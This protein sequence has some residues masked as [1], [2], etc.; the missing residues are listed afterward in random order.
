MKRSKH[1]LSSTHLTSFDMG[2]LVPVNL[3]ETL[4]GDS[5]QCS[6][7]ALI[8]CAPM[9]A[10]PMHPVRVR[11][12]HWFV[13]HRLVWA[14]FENFI[15]GGPDGN[16]A[17]VFPT[18]SSFAVAAGTL[19]N[20]LGLPV[21]TVP[22][23]SALPFRAY[24]L[25]WNEYYRD[26]DLQ[27][28]LTVNTGDGVDATTP[29]T[30][31]NCDWEKDYF[32]SS[33]PWEQKGPAVS[34]PIGTSAP[35]IR[36]PSSGA[37]N[38]SLIRVSSTGATTT[39]QD[40]LQ[41]ATDGKLRSPTHTTGLTLDPN[42]SLIADLSSVSGITVNALRQSLALQR[43]EEAR[44]R[45]GSRY[46]EYLRALG[47]RSSDARLQRPEY[48]GGGVSTIQFSEVMQTAQDSTN[49]VGTLRGHGITAMRSNRFRRFFEEHGYIIT[50]ASIL[51][52][53]IY[54]DG[55]ERSWNRR[56]K[57]DFWQKELENLGQ[58]SI[59]NKEIYA[60]SGTPDGV[61]GYQDRYDEY[62]RQWSRV[63]GEFATSVLDY[64]HFARKFASAPALNS[65]F[66]SA[67]PPS[68]AF[69][70]SINDVIYAQFRHSIQARR[71]VSKTAF[72]QTF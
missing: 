40:T 33:R 19:A 43:F 42:G 12:H 64:W 32:T 49:P 36:N 50:L 58:Q 72:P 48:L 17:S 56:T 65:T 38:S 6:T 69:A 67:V 63:S 11:I 61:F 71:L 46:A 29:V 28:A 70:S 39:A 25:I 35:V 2:Q 66:V 10:P 18:K 20:Y 59:L 24:A 21:A 53:T 44:A 27:T 16:D 31:Q 9:L 26:Q 5:I 57:Y 54:M 37:I 47:V 52:K 22:A 23:V 41:H 7:S 45:Y 51:P 34:I 15:T 55:V 14:N 13:P 30:L 1:A 60:A 4:P 8:R 62:R 3:L 68:R